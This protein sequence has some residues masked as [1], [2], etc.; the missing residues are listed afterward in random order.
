MIVCGG[1]GYTKKTYSVSLSSPLPLLKIDDY[2]CVYAFITG[3]D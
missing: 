2:Y 3:A 1:G